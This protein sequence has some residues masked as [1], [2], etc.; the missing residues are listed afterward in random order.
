MSYLQGGYAEGC[1]IVQACFLFKL[2]G[3]AARI[4]LPQDAESSASGKSQTSKLPQATLML[5]Y[6]L[7]VPA[8]RKIGHHRKSCQLLLENPV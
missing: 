4:S 7:T 1:S 8:M 3:L 5:T 2:F 6:P